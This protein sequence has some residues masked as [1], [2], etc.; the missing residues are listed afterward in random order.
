M[1]P[2]TAEYCRSGE[3]GNNRG[4]WPLSSRHTVTHLSV[5]PQSPRV[6]DTFSLVIA[7]KSMSF[8]IVNVP[9]TRP[10]SPVKDADVG[11]VE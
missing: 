5:N 2:S 4:Y 1:C 11:L 7:G 6:R 10:E 3:P 8:P 9:E